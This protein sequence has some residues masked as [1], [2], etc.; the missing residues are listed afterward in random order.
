[1][2]HDTYQEGGTVRVG[3]FEMANDGT[4][5]PT[6]FKDEIAGTPIDPTTVQLEVSTGGSTTTYTYGVDAIVHKDPDSTGNYYADLPIPTSGRWFYTWIGSGNI[7]AADQK[8]FDVKPR[9]TK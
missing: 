1:M 5:T 4:A 9:L 8:Y 2:A 7:A 6:P 3:T